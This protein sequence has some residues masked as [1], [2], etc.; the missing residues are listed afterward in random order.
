MPATQISN[1][2]IRPPEAAVD[3]TSD[4]FYPEATRGGMFAAVDSEAYPS[5]P[6][7]SLKSDILGES[8]V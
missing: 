8:R 4:G 7:T 6:S 5:P 2:G 1:K 3:Q